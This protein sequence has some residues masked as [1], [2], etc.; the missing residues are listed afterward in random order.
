MKYVRKIMV[1]I[2]A[3]SCMLCPVKAGQTHSGRTDS[4]G[5]HH[6]YNNVSGLGSYHYHHGYGPHLHP[7]GLCPYDTSSSS[8]VVTKKKGN[9][10]LKKA[11]RKLNR[12][13]Y[14]CGTPDG[15]MGSR[16]RKAL[17]KFQKKNKIK[18]TGTL[19][20]KTKKK[21]GI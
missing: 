4:A 8:S 19:T 12:L 18:V 5:G 11:Q 6:D 14:N 13:G 3:V 21:L 9:V 2:I 10:A 7:N 15:L 17:R 16:T 1:F 20:K